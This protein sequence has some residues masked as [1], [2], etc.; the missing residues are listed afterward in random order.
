MSARLHPPARFASAGGLLPLTLWEAVFYFVPAVLLFFT[1]F[2]V[3][4]RYQ[5]VADWTL[6]NYQQVF[7]KRIYFDAYLTSI[8][9]SVSTVLI[10]VALAY[11]AAYAVA[12][13][14]PPRWQRACMIAMIIPF[15][16]NYLVRAYA[17]QLVL[18][19]NGLINYV[20]LQTGLRTEP[21][22]ILYTH[23][24]TRIGLVHFLVVLLT[25]ALYTRMESIDRNLLEAARDL[26]ASRLRAFFEVI[27]PLTRGAAITGVMFIF[28]LAFADF[29]S[30]AVLGGQTRRVFPQLVVDA[31]QNDVNYPL[32][33]AFA[34]VM[35]A[36]IL[37]VVGVLS[38]FQSRAEGGT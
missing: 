25:L 1:S 34:T 7:G 5:L 22:K 12:F 24:A 2:W 9:L 11:P 31:I 23:V 35:V 21:V 3:M 6:A 15:W 8:W 33:A 14:V 36:T 27:V 28:V 19:N 37:L 32:A 4:Q 20:L 17:W 38:R 13:V 10:A 16:T 29:I 26:G 30:P 18:A